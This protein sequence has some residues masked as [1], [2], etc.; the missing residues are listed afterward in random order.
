MK[1]KVFIHIIIIYLFSS[2]FIGDIGADSEII[3]KHHWN[4]NLSDYDNTIIIDEDTLS[5]KNVQYVITDLKLINSEKTIL[6][7]NIELIDSNKKIVIDNTDGGIYQISFNF[8][9]KYIDNDYP[10]L[11][12]SGFNIEKGYY[13]MKM[14]FTNN[15]ND[16]IYNYNI[17]KKSNLSKINSFNVTIDGYNVGNGLFVNQAV[18]GLNLKNLFTNPNLINIDSLKTKNIDNEELQIKMME[19]AKNIFFLEEFIYD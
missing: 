2:C 14:N 5:L 13:F 9:V 19:N 3:F 10:Q 15:R 4:N 6:I 17:S 18:I 16:S 12:S 7:S 11:K 8:G 1:L